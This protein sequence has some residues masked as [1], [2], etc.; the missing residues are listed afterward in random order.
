MFSKVYLRVTFF[1]G[2]GVKNV[3]C[4]AKRMKRVRSDSFMYSETKEIQDI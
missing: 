4:R 3:F 2:S 1:G